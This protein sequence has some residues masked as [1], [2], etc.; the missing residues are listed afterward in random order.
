MILTGDTIIKVIGDE[1]G[2]TEEAIRGPRRTEHLADVRQYC[3]YAFDILWPRVTQSAIAHYF[4]KDHT[5]VLYGIRAAARKLAENQSHKRRLDS[6][7]EALGGH[8]RGHCACGEIILGP[9][10][11]NDRAGLG[12]SR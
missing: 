7:I 10:P 9:P 8:E 6:C 4:N 11:A 12:L 3:Y 1:F 2:V 5:T